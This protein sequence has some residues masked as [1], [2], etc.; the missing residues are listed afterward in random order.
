MKHLYVYFEVIR[1]SGT[2]LGRT[3]SGWS[4]PSRR[5]G[6]LSKRG[7]RTFYPYEHGLVNTIRKGRDILKP[8]DRRKKVRQDRDRES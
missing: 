3:E 1:S 4:G 8:S 2:L 6:T 7:K 5:D